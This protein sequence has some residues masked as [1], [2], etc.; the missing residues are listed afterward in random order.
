VLKLVGARL[1]EVGGDGIAFRYGGEEFSVLFPGTALDDALLYLEA[2]RIS[3]EGY[4]MA[5]R[6]PDRPK[7]AADGSKRRGERSIERHLSVTVSIGASGPSAS[8]ATPAQVIKAAD[9]A[10]Y[11]AKQGGRN[12]VST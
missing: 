12:R 3:I 4:R 10:L 11:R 2:I 5:V 1:A 6:A 7:T 9:E 8:L